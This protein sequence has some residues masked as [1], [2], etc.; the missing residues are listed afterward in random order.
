MHS[1]KTRPVHEGRR[2]AS[3]N[4]TEEKKACKHTNKEEETF[5]LKIMHSCSYGNKKEK[6]KKKSKKK[7]IVAF[8]VAGLDWLPR[9]PQLSPDQAQSFVLKRFL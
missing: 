9:G 7:T 1:R 4:T 6:K 5:K 2:K 8:P 3:N